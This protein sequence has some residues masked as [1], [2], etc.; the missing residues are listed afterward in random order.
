MYNRPKTVAVSNP[1]CPLR[2]LQIVISIGLMFYVVHRAQ[3]ELNAAIAA[4]QMELKS[5][6]MNGS[7]S[8]H[9]G[10]TY[11]SKRA[12][13]SSGINVVWA[14]IAADT[15]GSELVRVVRSGRGALSLHNV[16][17]T[18]ATWN[19]SCSFVSWPSRQNASLVGADFPNFGTVR[20]YIN[21]AAGNSSAVFYF[22]RFSFKKLFSLRY[23]NNFYS[24]TGDV[25]T[26]ERGMFRA[27]RGVWAGP[28]FALTLT[29]WMCNLEL[30]YRAKTVLFLISVSKR[31]PTYAPLVHATP[32][33]PWEISMVC[34]HPVL[35][36][37]L[38]KEGHWP[39]LED[40]AVQS[41]LFCL[42]CLILGLSL[43]WDG[44][45]SGAHKLGFCWISVLSAGDLFFFFFFLA[46]L[47]FWWEQLEHGAG[48]AAG[49]PELCLPGNVAAPQCNQADSH[50]E[51]KRF[52][53][54]S[55]TS[56]F[57]LHKFIFQTFYYFFNLAVRLSSFYV[58]QTF[59][60]I[61]CNTTNGNWMAW[62]SHFHCW[63]QTDDGAL[64]SIRANTNLSPCERF[65][66]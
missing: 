8:G 6:H 10:F 15:R 43:R 59:L 37:S 62:M 30:F 39:R 3:V 22:G 42:K 11:C 14:P 63:N 17:H 25:N 28:F 47:Q 60:S 21:G 26:S 5:S 38:N 24:V 31:M 45:R 65:S 66:F 13:A 52:S 46:P 2:P 49:D 56:S 29:L 57:L 41:C 12:A 50:T 53:G 23:F 32:V 34:L 51:L 58:R 9:G 48:L 1:C 35:V 19:T 16:W 7:S 44:E 36:C 20:L 54:N 40:W 61:L 55:S 27:V 33:L 18:V 64:A 4:C